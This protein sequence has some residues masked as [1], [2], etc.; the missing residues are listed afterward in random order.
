[1]KRAKANPKHSE[2]ETDPSPSC[3]WLPERGIG[4]YFNARLVMVIGSFALTVLVT[5]AVAEI[6]PTSR[7]GWLKICRKARK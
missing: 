2:S 5:L 7:Y 4:K 1:M 6:G 3:I